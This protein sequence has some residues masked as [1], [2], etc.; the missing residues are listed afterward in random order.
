MTRLAIV[1]Q[2]YNPAGGAERFVSRALAALSADGALEVSLIARR[3]EKVDGIGAITVDPFYLGNVWRDWGFARAARRAWRRAG[4]ELVQSHERIPGCSIYRAGDGVHAA[5]LAHRKRALGGF[6]RL[7]LA[8]NPYHAYVCRAERAM[9]VDP[10]L[11]LV[12]CN[13]HMVKREIQRH[14]GLPD[15]K[16]AVVYNGVDTEAFHPRLKAE[17]RAAM[18]QTW[19]IPDAAPTLLYVGSGF[20]RKGVERALRAIAPLAGVH[21]V[22]VGRDKHADRYQRLAETLGVAARVRFAGAQNDVRPFY[23]MA[24]AFVLPT[25]YDPFPNV[26]V[27]ALACGLP[28]FTTDSCGASELVR[29]GEN[30]WVVDALD[31]DGLSAAIQVWLA[32]EAAWPSLAAAA[33]ASAEPLTL[34]AMARQLTELYRRF[35]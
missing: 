1:R 16:F 11:K 7:S 28:V 17:H 31:V 30:G 15:E 8:F 27:E 18:R 26:C 24:D 13:A 4:F 6:K 21:L 20:E 32:R 25:L 33:R 5:W 9:F 19:Q 14:F 34:T 29:P 23:G 12:I 3:W 2:K 22:V 10:A 35:L